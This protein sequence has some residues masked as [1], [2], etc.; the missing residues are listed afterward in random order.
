MSN[1]RDLAR[2][3]LASARR[4]SHRFRKEGS[5]GRRAN[6]EN[7]ETQSV[8]PQL[9]NES[10]SELIADQGWGEHLK[11]G[12]LF[13]RWSEI[14]GAEIAQ[15]AKPMRLTDGKLFIEARSTA[16]ATQLRLMGD[17]LK[18]RIAAEGLELKEIEVVGPRSPSWRRG[19]WTVKGGRGP[20]DTYG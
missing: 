16:W 11:I 20:R 14:V 12:D 5:S 1:Q 7:D 13:T 10:L 3:L 4:H 8:G 15:N 18:R 17:D 6:L 19:G 9:I 2:A